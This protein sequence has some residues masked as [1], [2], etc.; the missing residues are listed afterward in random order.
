MREYILQQLRDRSC[1]RGKQ[2]TWVS[3]LSDDQL[4]QMFFRLRNGENSKAIARFIQNAWGVNPESS[5]HSLS[6]GVGKF[7]KRIAHLLETPTTEG[8]DRCSCPTTGASTPLGSL[9]A[10][11]SIATRSRSR[12]HAMLTEEERTGVRRP[13]LNRDLQALAA[14]EKVLMKV[15]VFNL[16]HDDPRKQKKMAGIERDIGEK[17]GTVLDQMGEDGK[18]KIVKALDRF[19]ELAKEHAVPAKMGR[20]GKLRLVIPKKEIP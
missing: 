10:L 14:L 11:E 4:Y 6:Q 13:F 19:M 18:V 17:F 15:R 12:I 5:I 2:R 1:V 8:E 7:K 20:D 3:D 9:E 16:Y